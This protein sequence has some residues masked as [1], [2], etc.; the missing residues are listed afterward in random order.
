MKKKIVTLLLVIFA[1]LPYSALAEEGALK[2]FPY[3]IPENVPESDVI[4]H[5]N[6]Y[7]LCNNGETKFADWVA[8]RLDA[9]TV[10]NKHRTSRRWKRD[11]DLPKESTL[12]PD[13]YKGANAA[14]KTDRGH[15]AP[16]ASFKGTEYW[17]MTNYL[18]NITPQKSALNQG[19]WQRVEAKVRS[20]AKLKTVYV[21]TG[22]LYER[23]IGKLPG[24]RKSHKVPSGYWKIIAV[25]T[26]DSDQPLQLLGF[27]FDQSTPRNA[28]V[29]GYTA[30]VNAIEARTGF[31]FFPGLE[32]EYSEEVVET[33][34]SCNS[35][36]FK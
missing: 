28:D 8:Y 30:T 16:L 10:A 24:T 14:L 1:V 25:K 22:P 6:I 11:S 26:N 9:S 12:E 15:Q 29:K 32:K 34:E 19:P 17:K 31:N 13:D 2:H 35:L 4:I 33:I 23:E 18:S 5:R 3:G 20:L 7:S 27:I 21:I 36:V